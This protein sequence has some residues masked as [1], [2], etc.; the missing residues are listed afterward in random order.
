LLLVLQGDIPQPHTPSLR[1][2]PPPVAVAPRMSSSSNSMQHEQQQ[3]QVS[4]QEALVLMQEAV[5]SGDLQK[6]RNEW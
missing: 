6:V 2:W 1:L 5:R 4:V 3:Q